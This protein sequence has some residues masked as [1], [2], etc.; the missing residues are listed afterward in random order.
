MN[1]AYEECLYMQL[2]LYKFDIGMVT[3]QKKT[4]MHVNPPDT[5]PKDILSPYIYPLDT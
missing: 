5:D 1:N 4:D 2:C 3:R